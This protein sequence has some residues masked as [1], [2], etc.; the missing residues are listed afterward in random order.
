LDFQQFN[1]NLVED[2]TKKEQENSMNV[3]SSTIRRRGIGLAVAL[4]LVAGCA[5]GALGMSEHARQQG[6][7][8]ITLVSSPDPARV[9]NSI[10]FA[11]G[12]A[13]VVKASLPAV[14]NISSTKVI[15]NRGQQIPFS[16][17]PFFQQFFG[18]DGGKQFQQQQP[19]EQKEYALGSGVVVSPEGYILT[20]NHVVEG[21]SDV[22]VDLAD[23]RHFTAKIVGMDSRTDIAVLKIEAS[24]LTAMPLGHSG[25]LEIGDFV[26]AIGNPFGVGE[27][28]SMGIV[29]ALGRTSLGIEGRN[30]YEN[31]IQTDAAINHGNSGGALVDVHGELVGINTAILTG[32]SEM[33]GGGEGSAGVGFAVP[34]DLAR[35][36]MMQIVEHG[37]VTRAE[38]GAHIQA[39]TP[40]LAKQFNLPKAAGAIILDVVPNGPAAKAGLKSG[41]VILG[42]DGQE[43]TDSNALR[44]HI[45]EEAPGTTARLQIMRDGK[46][47]EVTMTLDTLKDT[48]QSADQDNDNN[49]NGESSEGIMSGVSVQSLTPELSRELNI[50]KALSGVV[51]SQVSPDSAA[52]EA[53]VQRGDV[54][55]EVNHQAVHNAQEYKEAIAHAGKSSVLLMLV[56][57]NSD[58]VPVFV[59]VGGS[60]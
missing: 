32:G 1:S 15:K 19:R 31:F 11:N 2:K 20:N 29:S 9:A 57:P 10:S 54:I 40:Q 17:D 30:S 25:G 33:G 45:A 18:P 7:A 35:S 58:G 3:E 27:S 48:D 46:P 6:T 5:I 37:K 53:G 43:Y 13:P 39:V 34:I 12:F 51:V 23:K 8:H 26:L 59:V 41:D 55:T 47:M 49:G 21:A 50:T 14:V 28:V 36:V 22:T 16:N 4:A 44:L 52:A 42:M 60:Q 24:G 38:I 56:Q